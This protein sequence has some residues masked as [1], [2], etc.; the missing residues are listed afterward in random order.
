MVVQHAAYPAVAPWPLM[1]NNIAR[2]DLDAVCD[3]LRQDDPVLTQSTNVRAFEEEWS[4]WLGVRHS[5]FVN[6]GSS[7][8]LLTLAAL[9]ELY[10]PGGEVIVPTITWVSD[11]AAVLHT[12]FDPIF[13]D[14]DPRTLG[15]DNEQVLDRITPRTRAVFLTHV[16]GYNA[17]GWRLLDE[18]RRRGIPL[19]EDV[20]ES[21]GATFEGRRLGTFGLSSNFSFYYAH[22]LSTIEGGMVCTNNADFYE[23]VRMLR[24]H[25]LVRE[26]DSDSRKKEFADEYPDLNPEF[27]FAHAAY[28]V[29]GTEI[30]AVIGRSQLRRLDDGIRRRTENLR[31][32]LDHLDPRAFRTDFA[33]A[34]S[35]NYAFTLVLREADPA[36]CARV[37]EALRANG[38]EFRR[39]T[40]G[41]GNQV[42]Q[43]YLRPRVGPDAGPNFPHADHVHFYG[44]YIGNYPSLERERILGL[45]ELL[46]GLVA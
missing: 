5:V 30:N 4:R 2:E 40:S 23:T 29:R 28:N 8:N 41:G 44:F 18:L 11:I 26:L 46:N 32:F 35:S 34:G 45:C 37:M 15:M 19:I 24:S 12:G 27:I 1:R 16:L 25:G 21:H 6:S 9:K 38:I 42:R 14:I 36:L 3:L 22:H 43:P 10:G 33:T 7:A 31:L 39:G 20:C 17:L 13:V